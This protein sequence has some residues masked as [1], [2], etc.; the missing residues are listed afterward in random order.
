MTEFATRVDAF[1]E[2]YFAREPTDATSAGNHAYDGLW[3]E[4]GADAKADRLDFIDGWRRTFEGFADEALDVDEQLDRDLLLGVLDSY[5]FNEVELAEDAWS[6]MAWVYLIG[7]GFFGL[8]AREYAP[9]AERLTSIASR[10]ERL[11]AVL[12][13]AT[14]TL[15]GTADRP[16]DR[17]HTETALEQWPG[18]IGVVDEAIASGEAGGRDR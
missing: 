7:Q 1:F 15:V 8:I 9:L 17:F 3:P 2:E 4:L 11:P 6:P 5:R 18:L 10:A 16:V 14:A 13:A 12:D